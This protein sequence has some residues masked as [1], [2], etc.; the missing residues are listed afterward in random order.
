MPQRRE[1][2]CTSNLQ[3][4]ETNDGPLKGN[5]NDE[6]LVNHSFLGD[7]LLSA[8]FEA[9]NIKDLYIK[10]NAKKDLSDPN[11]QATVCRAMKYSFADIGDIIRG[12]DMWH[13][14]GGMEKLRGY[15]KT[16]FDKIKSA[17]DKEIISKYGG[18]TEHKQLREDWWEANRHQVWNAMKCAYSGGKCSRVPLDDYIPQRLR[19]MT[20]WA[21]WFCKMQSQQY[22]KLVTGCTSC[23]TNGK[24]GDEC[25]RETKECEKCMK[26]CEEYKKEIKSW[27]QQWKQMEI[28]YTLLY[29]QAQ[30][31]SAG[32]VIGDPNDQ[33]VIEFLKHLL[34]PKSDKPGAPTTVTTPYSTAEGYIH[35]ELPYTGCVSQ[36]NEFC[37][38]GNGEKYAFKDP[39]NGYDTACK[40]ME[41]EEKTKKEET[42]PTVVDVCKTVAEA[43]TEDNLTQ[44]CQ[45]KYINGR[46]KFPNWKCIPTSG[47]SAT[48][49]DSNQGSIC[50]P[51]RRRRLYVKKLHDWAS[52]SDTQVSGQA[53]TQDDT[54]SQPDPL[55]KAFVESAAVET[56]FLWDR[57]KKLNT[58]KTQGD[59]SPLGG[60]GGPFGSVSQEEEPPDKQL[61]Q[62][63]IPND[64]LRQMFYTLGD[65]RDILVRGGGDTNSGSKK[66]GGG[67][68][69]DRN[70]V[71]NAGG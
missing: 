51:P 29:L 19:W 24:G 55:L 43:L 14:E 33:D 40:C 64:F 34:P 4:L 52:G 20:E 53:Q 63:I 7:V 5:G 3:Y 70:I 65:Y 67:S 41:N 17:L 61:Q 58:K 36:Q 68:N 38:N 39:P 2:M 11:D 59:G 56:F 32:T 62:G 10:N 18:D 9:K 50:I 26:A 21:E 1:H 28:K 30:R 44:A 66:E 35:Q 22:N 25:Y 57:Y 60:V 27:E 31:N 23:M 69:S 45:Q 46:E 49:S 16:I 48:S 8:N 47:E 12:R 13:K 6:K 54:P 71:L 42:Q 15:L 37:K